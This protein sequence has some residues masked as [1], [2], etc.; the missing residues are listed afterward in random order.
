MELTPEDILKK[1]VRLFKN[2]DVFFHDYIPEKLHGRDQQIKEL[3]SHVRPALDGDRPGNLIIYGV[4]GSGKTAVTL[5][6]LN[7]LKKVA[8]DENVLDLI[9]IV[10][11]PCPEARTPTYLLQR[12]INELSYEKIKLSGWGL[13]VYIETLKKIIRSLSGNVLLFLD[14]ID[15]VRNLDDVLYT[16]TRFKTGEGAKVS[17]VGISN[18][19]KFS[20]GLDPRVRSSLGSKKLFFPPYSAN[21]LICILEDRVNQ[22]I[23]EGVLNEEVVPYCAAIAA[24]KEGDAR[25]AIDLLREAVFIAEG[26]NSQKVEKHHVDQA[27]EKLESDFIKKAVSELTIHQQLVLLAIAVFQELGKSSATTGDV[28]TSYQIFCS[29]I[30]LKPS[31]RQWV[32][33]TIGTLELLGIVN[34]ITRSRGRYGR[35][36]YISLGAPPKYVIESILKT[37]R[38][39]RLRQNYIHYINDIRRKLH[40]G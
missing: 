6:T 25:F 4:P 22:G 10:Y 9:H 11:I 17:L 15:K 18:N 33:E 12:I 38:F 5:Y 39:S 30:G 3:A 29:Y 37:E 2:R 34:S 31:T 21:D 24:Q 14:E 16:I 8:K 40:I 23:V 27:A 28:Y 20:E 19:L 35:T 1:R 32:S 13:A 36:R 26:E 7:I